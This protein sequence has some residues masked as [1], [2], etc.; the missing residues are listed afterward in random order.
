MR[1]A[2]SELNFFPR[3]ATQRYGAKMAT[4]WI[5]SPNWI[6]RTTRRRTFAKEAADERLLRIA[7]VAAAAT[8][9]ENEKPDKSIQV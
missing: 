3:T 2:R 8:T 1:D 9:H 4:N 7:A 5:A 6:K